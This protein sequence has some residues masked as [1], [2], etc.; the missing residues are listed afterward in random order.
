MSE[1]TPERTPVRVGTIV[2][3]GILLLVAAITA[4]AIFIDAT[5]YT[6]TFIL[7]SIV[8]FGA[9]LVFGGIVGAVV[10]ASTRPGPT[11]PSGTPGESG[12]PGLPGA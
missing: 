1:T 12:D 11:A 2:W 7:W 6:P 4:T 5:I 8:G 10:R 9:L 3:G